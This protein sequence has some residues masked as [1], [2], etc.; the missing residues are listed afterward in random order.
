MT[1]YVDNMRA[2]FGPMIMC[3][4]VADSESELVNMALKIGLDQKWH[5][6]PGTAKSHFDISL[7]KR[8]L[9]IQHGA[10]ETTSREVVRII[11]RKRSMKASQ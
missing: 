9:A 4:M 7:S 1:V 8:A 3:H 2:K 6:F 5:Q 10:V 11:A